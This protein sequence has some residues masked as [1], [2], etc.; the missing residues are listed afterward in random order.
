MGY[1]VDRVCLET[2]L[3]YLS[4]FKCFEKEVVYCGR[5]S[6]KLQVCGLCS[7]QN[8][9]LLVHGVFENMVKIM[10]DLAIFYAVNGNYFKK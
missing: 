8:I 7:L 6:I 10:L 4:A 2:D 5:N 3:H 9:A 1:G